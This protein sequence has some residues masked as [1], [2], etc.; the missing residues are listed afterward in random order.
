MALGC[1]LVYIVAHLAGVAGRRRACY[2]TALN[3]LGRNALLFVH[4]VAV[5][6]DEAFLV[7]SAESTVVDAFFTGVFLLV[8]AEL[9]STGCA[10]DAVWSYG[11]LVGV[12]LSAG[13][14]KRSGSVASNAEVLFYGLKHEAAPAV[15]ALFQDWVVVEAVWNTDS[16]TLS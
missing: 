6:A 9:E 12:C 15:E 16:L 8:E 1:L 2:V 13:C 3:S 10:H 14:A 5:L 7:L 11:C 4:V